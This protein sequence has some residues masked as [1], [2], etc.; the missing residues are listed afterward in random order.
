MLTSMKY[1]QSRPPTNYAKLSYKRFGALCFQ[2]GISLITF[3]LNVNK[4]KWYSYMEMFRRYIVARLSQGLHEYMAEVL[5][6]PFPESNLP[7]ESSILSDYSRY[8]I[9]NLI[10]WLLYFIFDQKNT[11]KAYEWYKRRWSTFA[12]ALIQITDNKTY[13]HKKESQGSF[14]P[15]AKSYA[16]PTLNNTSYWQWCMLER[17]SP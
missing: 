6:Y 7:Y 5:Y 11:P 16:I 15:R 13:T 17:I 1:R 8:I 9:E 2:T 3:M 12:K 4:R 14:L 10:T